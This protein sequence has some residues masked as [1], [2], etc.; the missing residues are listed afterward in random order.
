MTINFGFIKKILTLFGENIFI[1]LLISLT[2]RPIL[3]YYGVVKLLPS[4]KLVKL[5]KILLF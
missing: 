5:V 2:F 3:R 1:F 4:A